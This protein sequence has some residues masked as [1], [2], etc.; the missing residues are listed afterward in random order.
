MSQ[1]TWNP[2]LQV[3]DSLTWVGRGALTSAVRTVHSHYHPKQWV[4]RRPLE[5]A[6]TWLACTYWLHDLMQGSLPLIYDEKFC[7]CCVQT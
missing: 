7:P 1:V 4:L 2:A 6:A 5:V 3:T